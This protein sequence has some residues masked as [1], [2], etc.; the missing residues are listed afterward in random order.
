MITIAL[1]SQKGGV[2]KTTLAAHLAAKAEQA[3][4]GPVVVLDTD[5]QGTLAGWWNAREAD[6]LQ[7]AKTQISVLTRNLADLRQRGFG[8]AVIDTPPAVTASNA[9][10]IKMADLVIIPVKAS[11]NDLS[12]VGATID[13]VEANSTPF[14]FVVNDANRQAIITSTAK[15]ELAKHGIVAPAIIGSRVAFA[16]AMID[17]RTVGEVDASNPGAEEIDALWTFTAAQ[18]AALGAGEGRVAHG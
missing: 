13:L 14:F 2:G 15:K 5:P 17:G 10:V 7:F 11:P 9:Q 18:L 16:E 12:A 8:L 6:D 3:G 4:V 1:A